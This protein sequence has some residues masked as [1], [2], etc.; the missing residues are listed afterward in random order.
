MLKH[1]GVLIIL[2]IALP[3]LAIGQKATSALDTANNA[4]LWKISA[5]NSAKA[6]YIFGTMH[7]ICPGDYV[8][9]KAMQSSLEQSDAI[10]FEMDLTDNNLQMKVALGLMDQSGKLLKDYFTATEYKQIKAYF[11]DSLGLTIGLYEN[12]KLIAVDMILSAKIAACADAVSYEEKLMTWG[13]EKNKHILGLEAAEEQIALLDK[14]PV[15]SIKSDILQCI[16]GHAAAKSVYTDMVALYKKQKLPE[17]YQ[18]LIN[19]KELGESID[20]LLGERNI[21]WIPKIE[22]MT[23]KEAV[24]I[25]VGCGH[26]W[27]AAGVLQL[28]KNDGYTVT[29]IK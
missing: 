5:K 22:S 18:L 14:L 24:F 3:A 2:S 12:M 21:K 16:T 17:L 28:L 10:C 19:S 9:T 7:Q 4:I 11:K 23:Q 25:A 20:P 26:L 6:S 8:W 27:G 13:R 29:P 1:L 15:D